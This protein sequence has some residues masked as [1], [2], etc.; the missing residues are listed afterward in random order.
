MPND[1]N[2]EGKKPFTITIAGFTFGKKT[3]ILLGILVVIIVISTAVRSAQRAK[4]DR[5]AEQAAAEAAAK[6]A[7]AA[8]KLGT[9]EDF[10]INIHDEIQKQL[11][12]Q[13]GDAPEGFEWGYTGDLVALGNDDE[14]TCED[15]VY[16]FVRS[17]SILDFSTAERYSN[18]SVTINSYKQ[19]YGEVNNQITD[20]YNNF[21]RKQFKKSLTS[22]EINNITDTSVFS[23][24]TQYVTLN[25][26]VIDLTDKDFWQKD[27]N[28]LFKQ[29]R[30]YRETEKDTAKMHQY[31]YDY[32]YQAY[33]E[34]KIDK[35]EYTIEL[36]ATKDNGLGWL[37]TGDGELDAVLQYENGVD[38]AQ[39]IL[40]GF[41]K[42]YQDITLKEQLENIEKQQ[43]EI[44][45]K[46]SKANN[47]K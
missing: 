38:V 36:V 21:L 24:G 11:A 47:K 23:D 41:D 25:V 44:R 30:I 33:E 42:W 35:K 32:I 18:N 45:K 22:I 46:T 26:S 34:G 7:E 13:Y 37:I 39:Y 6:A 31:V 20:Y 43:K 5:E 2:N 15:V 27:K 8:N 12:D 10:K 16:M 29:M 4:E 9:K 1:S 19:Y 40:D 17:L 3:F 14:S 28:E